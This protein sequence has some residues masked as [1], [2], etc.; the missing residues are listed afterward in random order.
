LAA[1]SCSGNIVSSF[2]P[3]NSSFSQDGVL[4]NKSTKVSWNCLEAI[5]H[6]HIIT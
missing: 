3:L 6:S 4:I 1:I 2:L 5:D